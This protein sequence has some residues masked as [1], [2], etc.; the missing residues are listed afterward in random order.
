MSRV[1]SQKVSNFISSAMG[2]NVYPEKV[3]GGY[4][5]TSKSEE[6]RQKMT[7]WENPLIE[8]PNMSTL[9]LDI[10]ASI[11]NDILA[12]NNQTAFDIMSLDDFKRK[13]SDGKMFSVTFQ[14]RDSDEIRVMTARRG[15][16]KGVKNDPGT[17]GA[18]NRKALDAMHDI[19]T[20]YD[21]NKLPDD[22]AVVIGD[23]GKPVDT[24]QRGAFRRINIPGIR[25]IKVHG[26]RYQFKNN[27]FY[28]E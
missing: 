21:V 9:S 12:G 11:F 23:D 7:H 24:R 16:R 19:L 2:W 18:W 4:R 22:S 3:K 28:A 5:F 27:L 15:V 10:W 26:K 14:K 20:V 1:T 25:Q 6:T 17:N 13:I 8:V